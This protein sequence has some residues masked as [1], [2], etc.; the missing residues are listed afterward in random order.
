MNQLTT[1][2]LLLV[3]IMVPKY[4]QAKFD[5]EET[6]KAI[7]LIN[8]TAYL[9]DVN[10]SG[11]IIN[12]Y[13]RI[14]NYFSTSESHESLLARLSDGAVSDDGSKI[15]FYEKE[16]EPIP[17]YTIENKQPVETGTA[18]YLG[19]SPKRALLQTEAV[20]QIRKISES[21]QAGT[22]S[23]IMIESYHRDDYRSRALA[24]NRAAAIR[25]LLSAFG[26]D[27]SIIS[28]MTPYAL[29]DT[30]YDFV[31]VSF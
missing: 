12:T 31:K 24:R 22:I 21:Y 4:G 14:E 1:F 15:V 7:V 29:P 18:Q 11:N 25:D 17:S 2:F 26:T 16:V 5:V 30:K 23:S 3:I 19:F 13:Q 20:Q 8:G 9:V 10:E 27:V 6:K 28:T